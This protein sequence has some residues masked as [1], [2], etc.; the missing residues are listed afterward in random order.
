MEMVGTDKCDFIVYT[1]KDFFV[2]T[3]YKDQEFIDTMMEKLKM[4]YF[5]FL[6]PNLCRRETY[7]SPM[8]PYRE[9]TEE[10]YRKR[11]A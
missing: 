2:T 3:V 11:Y 4:F 6:L 8:P 1:E 5:R 9:I 10:L 7:S